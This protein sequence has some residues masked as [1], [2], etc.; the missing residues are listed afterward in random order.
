MLVEPPGLLMNP[1]RREVLTGAAVVATA[2]MLP[3][4]PAVAYQP[5]VVLRPPYT[6]AQG[7][8]VIVRATKKYVATK[9]GVAESDVAS[10]DIFNIV[11]CFGMSRD[12]VIIAAEGIAT[13]TDT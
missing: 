13:G 2:T 11:R 9:S 5:E 12:D 1:T 8:M 4:L 7:R 3:V 6:Q 10:D